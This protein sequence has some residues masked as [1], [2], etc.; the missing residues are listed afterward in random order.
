M[1]IRVHV[2][3]DARKEQIIKKDMS[4]YYITVKEPARQNRANTRIREILAHTHNVPLS[5]IKL[6]T[7]H[8]SST[9]LYGVDS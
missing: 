1:Y 8:R 2:A 9:K 7:G 4:T 3:V 5:S 6:L